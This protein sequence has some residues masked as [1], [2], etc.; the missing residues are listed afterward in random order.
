MKK[1]IATATII[2]V[3]AGTAMADAPLQPTMSTQDVTSN[4]DP[5]PSHLLVPIMM[6]MLILFTAGRGANGAA[7]MLEYLPQS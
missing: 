4:M 2:A 5:N 1:L 6:M 3:L 7:P